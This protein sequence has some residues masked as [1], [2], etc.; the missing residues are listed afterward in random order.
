LFRTPYPCPHSGIPMP[1]I[2]LAFATVLASCLSSIDIAEDTSRQ[3]LPFGH[4]IP[5]KQ[6]P[7]YPG[8][9]LWLVEEFD[10]PLDLDSDPVWTWSDGGLSE[11]QVRFVK[12]GIKFED[13]KMVLE[14]REDRTTS[15]QTCSHAEKDFVSP[16]HLT[17]G[18]LRARHN[19]FRYGLYEVRL[20][21]PSTQP[22]NTVINGNYIS[23]MFVFR[24]SKFMSWREIDIEITGDSPNSITMNL[25]SAE[26]Q[27]DWSPEI[28]QTTVHKGGS[29]L[30]TRQHFHTYAFEWLP[31]QITWYLDGKVIGRR[32]LGESLPIP[33]KSAKIMMNLWIFGTTWGFGG[34]DG[35][36]NRYPMRSEYEWFRFYAWEGDDRYPCGA[37]DTSCLAPED[38]VWSSNNPCD[39]IQQH[40]A[41]H[42]KTP[43]VATCAGHNMSTASK[44]QESR[45]LFP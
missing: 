24:D 41:H 2:P 39:Q 17:S 11:G 36:N 33:E 16:K 15:P 32:R 8:F 44:T 13:G 21:S 19:W 18:E 42:G 40:T 23:T 38:Q 4:P 22:G 34:E 45:W 7:H 27:G 5:G 12:E 37:M 25:L 14:A 35:H 20:K 26:D 6:Y 29:D 31:H 10:E 9:Q 28:Q 1:P 43:C 3:H 30:N